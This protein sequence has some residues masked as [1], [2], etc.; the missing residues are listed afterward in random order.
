M[1]LG[2]RSPRRIT[3]P[4]APTLSIV[5]RSRASAGSITARLQAAVDDKDKKKSERLLTALTQQN[6][7]D[8]MDGNWGARR[9]SRLLR[10][11]RF[12]FLRFLCC[13]ASSLA[14]MPF[15]VHVHEKF[16]A[17]SFV[18]G[19]WAFSD[20]PALELR[21][22]DGSLGNGH[23]WAAGFPGRSPPR[24]VTRESASTPHAVRARTAPARR[25]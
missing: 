18:P 8:F 6:L 4:E 16:G 10:A 3:F 17:E 22:D 19:F 2:S 13:W 14:L 9:S 23:G 7:S 15:G 1:K 25:R 20:G 21:V 5:W 11:R 12:R 24:P